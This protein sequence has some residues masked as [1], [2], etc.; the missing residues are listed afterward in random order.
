MNI[1]QFKNKLFFLILLLL[2]M[3]YSSLSA[4]SNFS[5][6]AGLSKYELTNFGIQWHVSDEAALSFA[7]GS[8]F[9]INETV[10]WSVGGGINEIF[11]IKQ[12]WTLK[13]GYSLNM[14][15]WTREDDLYRFEAISMPLMFILAYPISKKMEVQVS[16][17]GI[18]TYTITS[19]RKQNVHAGYPKRFDINLGAKLVYKLDIDEE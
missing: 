19:D 3:V 16:G 5:V 10:S 14:T 6:T 15:Y 7:I 12:G 1:P 4:Q 8:N 11:G 13:P 2:V 18:G 17:G 9:G